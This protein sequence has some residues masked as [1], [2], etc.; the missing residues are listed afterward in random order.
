MFTAVSPFPS[1]RAVRTPLSV[2]SVSVSRPSRAI[3]QAATQR[4]ALPQAPAVDP[5]AF[6]NVSRMSAASSASI[7]ASWSNP[8]PRWRS[9]SARASAGVT[10]GV[11]PRW[12]MTTKSLPSPCIFMKGRPEGGVASRMAAHIAPRPPIWK[13]RDTPPGLPLDAPCLAV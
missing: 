6:Q 7:T 4:V 8:T 2:L 13:R 1:A 10:N 9:P 12:S 3:S 5:S 11:D